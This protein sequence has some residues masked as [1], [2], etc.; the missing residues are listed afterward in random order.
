MCLCG[1][2]MAKKKKKRYDGVVYST[3]PDFEYDEFEQEEQ[4]TLPPQQQTLRIK[5]NRLKGN[6]QATVVWDFVGT[7]DDFKGLGKQL[8]SLCGCGGSVKNGE[9]ILQGDFREK[10]KQ[11][12]LKQGYKVKMVGG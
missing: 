3:D 5:L 9:I 12:L 10:V 11:A 1:L 6:K 8:K 7:D 4:E 2:K